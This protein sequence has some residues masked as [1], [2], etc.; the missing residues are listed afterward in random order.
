MNP[1]ALRGIIISKS[2]SGAEFVTD[3]YGDIF[4]ISGH[5]TREIIDL[6]YVCLH[7]EQTAWLISGAEY[8][9]LIKEEAE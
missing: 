8:L 1:L 9:F 6:T 2:C 5:I 7:F 3:F 4:C